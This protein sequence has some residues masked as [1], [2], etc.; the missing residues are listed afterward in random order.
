MPHVMSV[1]SLPKVSARSGTTRDTV[2]KSK[3]SQ[4]HAANATKKNSHCW[5]LSR[6]RVLKGFAMGRSGGFSEVRRVAQ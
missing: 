6:P 5:R 4:V 3:A 1:L 2:K